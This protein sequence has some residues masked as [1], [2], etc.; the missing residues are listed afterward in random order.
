MCCDVMDGVYNVLVL[1]CDAMNVLCDDLDVLCVMLYV[2]V[3]WM[4]CV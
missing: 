2:G 4:C 1:V 3:L